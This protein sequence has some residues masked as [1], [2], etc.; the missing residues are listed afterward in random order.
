MFKIKVAICDDEKIICNHILN[1][2]KEE[3]KIIGEKIEFDIYNSA[4]EMLAKID[5]YGVENYIIFLD[6]MLEGMNGV[7]LGKLLKQINEN[8]QIVFITSSMDFVLDGYDVGA[9]NYLLKPLDETKLRKVFS[10]L[11][12]KNIK[13]KKEIFTVTKKAEI[14]NFEIS[15]IL[16]FEINNRILTLY[17]EGGSIEFYE[18]IEDIQKQLED[19]NFIRPHRSYLVNLEHV[20]KV[21]KNEVILKNGKAIKISRLKVAQ[22]KEEFMEFIYSEK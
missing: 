9:Y 12:L 16:Y 17:Y 7:E 21:T 4:E 13:V 19:K 2:L 14:I 10:D 1:I 3:S 5:N 22:I 15:D 20:F 11:V 8:V 6:I 18:K